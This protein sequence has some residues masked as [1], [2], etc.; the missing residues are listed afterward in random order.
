MYLANNLNWAPVNQ[1]VPTDG[2]KKMDQFIIFDA[3]PWQET[4]FEKGKR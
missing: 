3:I 1:I 2:L 4:N